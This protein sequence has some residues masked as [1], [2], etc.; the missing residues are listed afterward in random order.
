[1]KIMLK[2]KIYHTPYACIRIAVRVG[3][4][5]CTSPIVK[6]KALKPTPLSVTGTV[7]A[8]IVF[9]GV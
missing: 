4:M 5:D 1:M 8:I 7:F 9:I 3:V 6:K 2:G